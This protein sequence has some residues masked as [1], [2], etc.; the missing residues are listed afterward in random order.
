MC[1]TKRKPK[2]KRGGQPGN[3]NASKHAFYS[4]CLTEED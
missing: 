3:Q 4:K 1:M 2:K